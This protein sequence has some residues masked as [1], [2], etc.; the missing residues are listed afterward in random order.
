MLEIY[1]TNVRTKTQSKKVLQYLQAKF[2]KAVVNFDLSDRDK[3]LRVNG[4]AESDTMEVVM[5]LKQ[6]GHTC[7]VLPF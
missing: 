3:I 7:E 1:K 5:H 6:L 2:T 4:I